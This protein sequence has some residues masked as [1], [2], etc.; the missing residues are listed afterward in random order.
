[1]SL[2]KKRIQDK[3]EIVGEYKIIQVR[4]SDQIIEDGQVI[5]SSYHRESISPDEEAKAIEH[6]VKALADIYWTDEIKEAYKKSLET[7]LV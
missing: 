7:P 3:I 1:M 6:N 4:Y 2:L 5:S